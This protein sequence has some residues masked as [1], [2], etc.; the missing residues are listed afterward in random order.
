[1][2]PDASALYAAARALTHDRR[3]GEAES[4]LEDAGNAAAA[5][6]EADLGARIAGTRAYVLDQL[7]GPEDGEQL[8]RA[9]LD[10]PGL[11]AHTRGVLEG[12]LGTILAHRGR[13]AE[14]A[15]WLGRA[16][17]Q[18]TDDPIAVANLRMNRSVLAMQLGDL[19]T[20]TTELE[21]A[22]A[23]YEVSGSEAEVAEAR[24]NLGYA[25]LI[26]G[27]LVRA[28]RE[29][30]AA[31]PVVAAAS[32]ANAAIC[33][34]DMAEA[35]RDAGLV[36][37]AERMLERAA[38]AFRANGM[39]QARAEAE[40]HLARS[41]LRHD[42][43]EAAKAA[44]RAARHFDAL[45][46]TAWR[47]RAQGIRARALLSGGSFGRSG[48]VVA[49]PGADDA[50][51]STL[52]SVLS[53]QGFASDATAL[54]LTRELWRARR[55]ERAGHA[56]AVDEAAPLEVRMLAHEVRAERAARSGDDAQVR[57]HAASGLDELSAWRSSFGSLDLQTSLAMHGNTL[58]MAGLGAAVRS[59][60]PEVVFDWSERA[61]HLSLQVVP[62]RPP[63]DPA[64]AAELSELRMLRTEAAGGEWSTDPR[65]VE[66]GE[67]LRRRQWTTTGA[68]G[69]E[70]PV[71][72][73]TAS[74]ALG[75]DTALLTYV[76]STE[77]LACLVV[78]ARG[79]ELVPLRAWVDARSD[80]PALRSDLDM[81]A[82]VRGG[83]MADVVR[84][85]LASR[86]ERLSEAILDAPLR[87]A[88]AGRVVITAPGVLAGLPW[89]MLTGARGRAI[90]VAASTTRWVR[91]RRDPMP[92]ATAA[93]AVG[94]RIARGEEEAAAGAAAWGE[95]ADVLTGETAS[96]DA[97][98]AAAGRADVLHIAAHGRQAVDNPLFSAVQLADGALFGYDIDRMPTVPRTVVLSACEAGRSAVRWG[99]E[100]VGM[101][102]AWLHA[103]AQVV[104]AAPV[105]VADDDACEVLGALHGGLARGVAPAVALAEATERTGI[106]TPFLCHGNGF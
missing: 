35:L 24:H 54:R 21:E 101:T 50:E 96:V 2:T 82:A 27:D 43:G 90:T 57:R 28:L 79:A 7:G 95:R 33:D 23:V 77:G 98:T 18:I 1:M 42:P 34:M 61:R 93:F 102:R 6:G 4:V 74:A 59:G 52:A 80:L 68:E 51:V 104:V 30:G 19:A 9:A 70:Q 15:D 89:N 5:A 103:G 63:A 31:R 75:C 22:V 94:P 56:P 48:R 41:L 16:I 10:A 66:L 99:E 14:A 71:D 97:V 37:E 47:D 58:M 12:Q 67:R 17:A 69:L 86:L 38:L 100:A 25:A 85:S 92:S 55:G 11:S 106:L 65:A 32:E 45:G 60:R 78:T 72:L 62:L 20:A 53:A 91:G 81:S 46:A 3:Y 83:P 88:D 26:G 8:C 64:Q 87:G 105:I 49:T 44:A 13:A 40:F 39:T 73:A 84:R 29:M 76:F 36:T